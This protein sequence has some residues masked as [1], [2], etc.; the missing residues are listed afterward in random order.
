MKRYESGDVERL[1]TYETRKRH[2]RDALCAPRGIY[3]YVGCRVFRYMFRR[4]NFPFSRARDEFPRQFL[5]VFAQVE[6]DTHTYLGLL[7]F[8]HVADF[9]KTFIPPHRDGTVQTRKSPLSVRRLAG[10]AKKTSS[11][12]ASRAS[13]T[14]TTPR[15]QS[16]GRRPTPPS[17]STQRELTIISQVLFARTHAPQNNDANTALSLFLAT[18]RLCAIVGPRR[19]YAPGFRQIEYESSLRAAPPTKSARAASLSTH[20]V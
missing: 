12:T 5:W 15:T 16:R 10:A 17:S 20:M 9:P 4:E 8:E 14:P 11:R 3:V 13:A 19:Y 7:S 18:R 1:S 2:P 6:T